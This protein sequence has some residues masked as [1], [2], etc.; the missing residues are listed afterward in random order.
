M[1]CYAKGSNLETGYIEKLLTFRR[2]AKINPAVYR[3]KVSGF[4]ND[5]AVLY[6]ELGAHAESQAELADSLP[7]C[8]KIALDNLSSKESSLRVANTLYIFGI[9]HE[10]VGA[11][12]RADIREY[13]PRFGRV[14]LFIL[15]PIGDL[16][17]IQAELG[18]RVGIDA[19]SGRGDQTDKDTDDSNLPRSSPTAR[20]PITFY[21]QGRITL[22]GRILRSLSSFRLIERWR[23]F[24]R[25][26]FYRAK[27]HFTRG[28][29]DCVFRN[30]D[31]M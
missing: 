27:C 9:L 10:L 8:L 3:P 2:L 24:K 1:V 19:L 15:S 7:I 4:L 17:Y 13:A 18:L 31:F 12:S 26:D 6:S 25:S 11:Y 16:P 29:T 21:R 14:F 30:M 20:S 22:I 28:L 23:V 5:L